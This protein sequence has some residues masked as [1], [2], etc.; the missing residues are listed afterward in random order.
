MCSD[1]MEVQLFKYI[2][3]EDTDFKKGL[4]DGAKL[5]GA[6]KFQEKGKYGEG[7]T[8]AVIDTGCDIKHPNIADRII[9]VR[10]FTT[11]NGGAKHLVTDYNGHGTHVAGIIGA[12]DIGDGIIGVAP[13][14]NLL[15]LKALS[16]K[17]G[18]LEWVVDAVKYAVEQKVDI[19]SMSL[20][21]S[22]GNKELHSAIKEAVDNNI[23]VVGACGN[24]GD[25]NP[26]TDEISYPSAYNEVISVGSADYSK[27]ISSFS[28]SNNQVDLLSFGNDVLS[29]GTKNRYIKMSGTSMA[30]PFVSGALAL[31]KNWARSEFKRELTESELYAQLIKRTVTVGLDSALEGNG[32]LYLPIEEIIG[33]VIFDDELLNKILNS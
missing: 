29:L 23:L 2:M 27:K 25:S 17:G 15:I 19:I 9:G 6:D 1:I 3:K 16:T 22:K 8:I 12:S 21:A 13:K 11:D 20:G 30:C 7:V 10:N 5:M 14:C 33:K 4:I 32:V 18:K 31:I 28:S 24:D 26:N